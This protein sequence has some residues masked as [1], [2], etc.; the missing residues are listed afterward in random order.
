MTN[1]E[2][3]GIAEGY[4]AGMTTPTETLDSLAVLVLIVFT[5]WFL[6]WT[7]SLLRNKDRD[8]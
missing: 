1:S 5:A 6:I 8:R 4:V 3:L 2:L 7:K